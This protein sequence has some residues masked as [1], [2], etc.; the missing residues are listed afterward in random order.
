VIENDNEARPSPVATSL[1]SPGADD[2]SPRGDIPALV[3]VFEL[4][5]KPR[6]LN[7][8]DLSEAEL[9]RIIDWIVSHDGGRLAF[10]NWLEWHL[11]SRGIR[12]A[13]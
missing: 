9:S 3:V 11:V 7:A 5:R 4:E 2:T 13:A 10:E 6:A 1:N 8:R 12:E